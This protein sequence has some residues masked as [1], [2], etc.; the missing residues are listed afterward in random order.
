MQKLQT[1]YRSNYILNNL[2]RV[3]PAIIDC[4][5]VLNIPAREC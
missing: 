3:V 5:N 1:G 2:L 4:I